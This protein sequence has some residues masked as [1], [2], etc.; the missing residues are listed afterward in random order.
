MLKNNLD[1]LARK[2]APTIRGPIAR[3]ATRHS[4]VRRI[5]CLLDELYKIERLPAIADAL[6]DAISDGGVWVGLPE[7][8][9]E[10]DRAL[11]ALCDALHAHQNAKNR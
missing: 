7:Y 9:R 8:V 1:Y 11:L 5:R 2:E 6:N 4:P 10:V 3:G